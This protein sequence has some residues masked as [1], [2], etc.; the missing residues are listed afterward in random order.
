M[1]S[2]HIISIVRDI[3]KLRDAKV[4]DLGALSTWHLGVCDKDDVVWLQI[5]VDDAGDRLSEPEV[6][7]VA[8][9]LFAAGFET[10]TNLIGNGVATVVVARYCGQL[11]EQQMNEVLANPA[12]VQKVDQHG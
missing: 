5:A 4:E 10:T 9:L 8:M 2:S 3:H 11:D 1:V 7:V 6:I 12:A